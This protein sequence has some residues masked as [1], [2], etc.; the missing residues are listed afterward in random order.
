MPGCCWWARRTRGWGSLSEWPVRFMRW[1]TTLAGQGGA[2][3]V[4]QQMEYQLKFG[5]LGALMDAL[6][7]R[8]KLDRSVAQVF[9]GLKRFTEAPRGID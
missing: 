8:R 9:L 4:S 1:K 6:V 2:T 3:L 5:P 7:M